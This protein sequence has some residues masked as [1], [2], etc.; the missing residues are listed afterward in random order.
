MLPAGDY[1]KVK[2]TFNDSGMRRLRPAP[3]ASVQW[4]I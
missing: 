4:N 2:I 3:P 1:G